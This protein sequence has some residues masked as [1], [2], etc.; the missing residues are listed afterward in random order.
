MTTL[1]SPRPTGWFQVGWS[2][3]FAVGEVRTLH[4]L[5]QELVAFRGEDGVVRILNAHCQHL[6]AHLGFGGCVIGNDIQCP[7]H[8]W[9]WDGA[10]RNTHIPYQ[11][12][13][14]TGR[15]IRSWSV[16]ERNESVYLWHDVQGREPLW[17]V[18][19]AFPALGAH[20]SAKTFAPLV[21]DGR[22]RHAGIHVHPQVVAENAVDPHHFRFVHRTPISPKVL[23]EEVDGHRWQAKVGFGRKWEDGLDRPEDTANT[24]EILWLGVG[25]SYSAEQTA[26][27]IRVVGICP[28]PVND[29]TTDIF[30]TYWI[31]QE[32]DV[33]ARLAQAKVALPDDINIWEHQ[34]Y[35]EPP[36]LAT[37][38]AAGFRRLRRWASSFYPPALAE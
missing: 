11:E 17:Q 5:G 15:R 8:G 34:I 18:P 26:D 38:E 9:R 16:A 35:L 20:V 36:A 30:A 1:P 32:G 3:D 24:I 6:G 22:S 23:R 12:R 27:G 21:P 37:S 25:L 33:D 19:D 31:S 10:G 28:T 7:F 14:N 29:T 2:V 4:Y 13:T